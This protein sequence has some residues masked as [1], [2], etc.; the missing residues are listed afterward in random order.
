M[1]HGLTWFSVACLLCAG[2]LGKDVPSGFSGTWDIDKNQSTA[3]SE[4]P[5]AL[6]QQIKHKKS[7]MVIKSK[8][9][10][11]QNGVAPLV[12]LGVMTTELKL[13]ANGRQAKKQFGPFMTTLST[14]QDADGVV[15]KWHV[16]ANGLPL[17]SE[18]RRTLGPDGKTMTL[19][20]KQT[21]DG[22]DKTAKLVFKR[23]QP[24]AK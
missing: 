14:T 18:W 5:D 24:Q 7:Q 3:S 8:W 19:D 22:T 13:D 10:E 1:R 11:P 23:R 9:M 2:V 21:G 15:T 20:I 6:E 16:N 17:T 4:I 12:L